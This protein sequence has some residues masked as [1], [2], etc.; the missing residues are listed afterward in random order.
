M[1]EMADVPDAAF[2]EMLV[3]S[4]RE[5]TER[6]YSKYRGVYARPGPGGQQ[7]FESRVE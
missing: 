2:L 4:S 7:L 3:E 6:R 5:P 1:E